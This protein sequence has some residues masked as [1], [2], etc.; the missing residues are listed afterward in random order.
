MLL[1]AKGSAKTALTEEEIKEGLYSAFEKLGSR[2]KVLALP[3]DFTRFHSRAGELT[4]YAYQ[5]YKEKLTDI[6]PALGTHFQMTEKE[7]DTMF[8]DVPKDI[9]RVHRWKEDLHTLGEVPSEFMKEVSEGKLSYTWP[10]QVNKQLV[11]GGF[12]LILSI[13]QVVPHEVIG[14]ANYNKR[15]TRRN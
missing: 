11:D 12:D 9:F 2:K 15:W 1:F 8:G 10:A 4:R 13:G 6:L 14:M 3:P 7:I 5:Y